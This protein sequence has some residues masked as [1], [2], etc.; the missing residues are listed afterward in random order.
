M[1][2]SRVSTVSLHVEGIII[3]FMVEY[4]HGTM[5]MTRTHFF[6]VSWPHQ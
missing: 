5:Y 2:M 3:S 6:S 1:R 4:I